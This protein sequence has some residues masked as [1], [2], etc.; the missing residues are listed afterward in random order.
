M[1]P[2]PLKTLVISL[3]GVV[4]TPNYTNAQSANDALYFLRNIYN[5]YIHSENG[6][7]APDIPRDIY[8]VPLQRLWNRVDAIQDN[9]HVLDAD[10]LIDAQDYMFKSVHLRILNHSDDKLTATAS[11]RNGPSDRGTVITFDL[12]SIE[13]RWKINNI[14]Y[15]DGSDLRSS[16]ISGLHECH[17]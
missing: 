1:R 8:S 12:S 6:A 4:F 10:P 17:G 7:G 11:F 16:L 3:T 15:S 13:G 14:H 9:C 2:I 5:Q